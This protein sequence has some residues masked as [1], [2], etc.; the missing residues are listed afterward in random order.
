MYEKLC[1][2]DRHY[3]HISADRERRRDVAVILTGMENGVPGTAE[4]TRY[5]ILDAQR[6]A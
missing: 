3:R 4:V 2:P 6:E 1:N 5:T